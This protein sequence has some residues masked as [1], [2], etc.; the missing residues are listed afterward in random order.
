MQIGERLHGTSLPSPIQAT[1]AGLTVRLTTDGSVVRPGITASFACSSVS[2]GDN[3]GDLSCTTTGGNAQE[4]TLCK[5]PFTYSGA[6]Y[7]D[8]TTADNAAGTLWCYTG[9]GASGSQW[10]N[11]HCGSEGTGV[12]DLST[13]ESP[14]EGST[15][16]NP[17][18]HQLS[19][20]GGGSEA[21]FSYSLPAGAT[22]EI[23]QSANDY[24]SRHELSVGGAFPGDASVQ[25]VD[26]PDNSRMT[27]TNTGSD[28]VNVY[29]IVDAYSAGSG[30]FTL[31]WT[32][33]AP[34]EGGGGDPCSD[35]ATLQDSGSLD[36]AHGNNE[37]CLWSISCSDTSR[38]PQL[39]F[40]A[41][42][43]ESN[44]DFLYLYDGDSQ[45]AAQIGDPL[46]GNSV[47]GPIRATNSAMYVRLISD[48]SV[49]GAG[50]TATL[51]CVTA[52][53]GRRRQLQDQDRHAAPERFNRHGT[54]NANVAGRLNKN[55]VQDGETSKQRRRT[56]NS[57][58]GSATDVIESANL[59]GF[60]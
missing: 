22:I 23:G 50:F 18:D 54:E 11:C 9:A 42:D 16:G 30:A 8:C 60:R 39:E 2:S 36:G 55:N 49:I 26:D 40:S 41:F 20:G 4:G 48:G 29:F 38:V 35:G 25:C 3:A 51:A 43:M 5:F 46:H 57:P 13:I 10:G 59:N 56:Q 7:T 1:G 32:I 27:W 53:S 34:E 21:G 45:S 6:T 19:C 12:T 28:A 14:Y 15:V 37:E 44:F 17:D 52:G 33:T 47:P 24:D 58:V 31:T